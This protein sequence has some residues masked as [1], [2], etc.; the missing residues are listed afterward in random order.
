ME[1]IY[2]FNVTKIRNIFYCDWCR[3]INLCHVF[4]AQTKVSL[5]IG[6]FIL[7]KRKS[8]SSMM[9]F[10]QSYAFQDT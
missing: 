1:R 10:L 7:A 3:K 8:T 4:K 9:H 5:G 2:E 6:F